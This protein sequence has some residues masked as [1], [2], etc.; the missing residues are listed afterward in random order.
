MSTGILN[1]SMK[2]KS[3]LE[4]GCGDGERAISFCNA[5]ARVTAIDSSLKSITIAQHNAGSLPISFRLL[6]AE[7]DLPNATY[8]LI[9]SHGGLS[10]LKHPMKFLWLAHPRCKELRVMLYS[11]Y[12]IDPSPFGVKTY[13]MMEA[14]HLM[15]YAGFTVISIKKSGI[16]RNKWWTRLVPEKLL[17]HH[18]EIVARP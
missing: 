11:R 4:I 17:G 6:N 14:R 18:I 3:V 13:T 16:E 12:S 1:I 9:Y 5:G 8:D 2:G 10:R 7:E 15:E